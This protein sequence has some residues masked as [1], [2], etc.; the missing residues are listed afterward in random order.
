MNAIK[1]YIGED[2][3]NLVMKRFADN[4]AYQEPP[5]TNSSIFIKELEQI[6]PDSLQYLI[7]DLFKDI[8]LYNNRAVKAESKKLPNGQFELQFTFEI[9]KLRADKDGKEANVNFNDYVYVG[10][11]LEPADGQ[12]KGK[13]LYY[14]LHKFN[15]QNNTITIT[16]DEEPAQAGI[17]PSYLLI[18]RI[19]EDNII[20][21]N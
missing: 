13:E 10:A 8:I 17:D 1:E 16:L 18:D 2:S 11:Y 5:Y 21:V 12:S 6:V 20:D 14:E 4:T 3:L 15:K 7:N 9:E 19:R